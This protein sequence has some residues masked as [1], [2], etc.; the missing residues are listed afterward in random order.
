[1]SNNIYSS[2]CYEV[3]LKRQDAQRWEE[4]HLFTF[5]KGWGGRGEGGGENLRKS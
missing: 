1:M 2:G 3:P 5:P 4:M